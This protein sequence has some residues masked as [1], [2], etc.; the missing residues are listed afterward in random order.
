MTMHFKPVSSITF[1]SVQFKLRHDSTIPSPYGKWTPFNSEVKQM[2]PNQNYAANKT[3]KVA[4]FTL[5]CSNDNGRMEYVHELQ[6]YIQ[7]FVYEF[8]PTF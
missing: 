8:A 6:K 3:K 5:D 4:W 1:Y 2:R 7:V